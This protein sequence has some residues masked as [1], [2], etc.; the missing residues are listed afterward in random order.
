MGWFYTSADIAGVGGVEVPPGGGV[1]RP[2]V[3]RNVD[4]DRFA[5]AGGKVC[6]VPELLR[7]VH[8]LNDRSCPARMK[9][10]YGLCA[11]IIWVLVAHRP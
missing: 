7:M 4:L 3:L 11:C 5:G 10:F 8:G 2:S 9:F 1:D 6:H